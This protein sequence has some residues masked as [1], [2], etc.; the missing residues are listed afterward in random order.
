M[1]FPNPKH[2][3]IAEQVLPFF[4]VIA[5]EPSP[6]FSFSFSQGA[7]DDSIS[8]PFL[9]LVLPFSCSGW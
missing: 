7:T 9:V 4:R 1:I 3:K 8:F 5:R 6:S 2:W